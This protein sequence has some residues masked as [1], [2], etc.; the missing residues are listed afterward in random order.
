MQTIIY[1]PTTLKSTK[2]QITRISEELNKFGG[3][4]SYPIERKDSTFFYNL[5]VEIEDDLDAEA[6]VSLGAL[7][8]IMEAE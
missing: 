6:L 4:H 8:G 3:I 7:I 5:K 2:K 1:N